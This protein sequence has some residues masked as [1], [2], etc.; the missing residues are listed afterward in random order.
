[1]H[2]NR[3]PLKTE[4]LEKPVE[5]E[6][7]AETKWDILRAS[8]KRQKQQAKEAKRKLIEAV[9]EITPSQTSEREDF[10][11]SAM[12][13]SFARHINE[14]ER[15]WEN[16]IFEMREKPITV[17]LREFN[18]ELNKRTMPYEDK[19]KQ[20]AEFAEA[21]L[22]KISQGTERGKLTKEV[23]I[24]MRDSMINAS[25]VSKLLFKKENEGLKNALR[26]VLGMS[27]KTEK[28][29]ER[30]VSTGKGP[31]FDA[32]RNQLSKDM[33][34]YEHELMPFTWM[35][36]TFMKSVDRVELAKTH[37]SKNALSLEKTIKF[38]EEGNKMGVF[39]PIEME[40]IV[41]T[42]FKKKFKGFS[43][44]K[45]KEYAVKYK[46]QHDFTKQAMKLKPTY[47]AKNKAGEMLTYKNIL[48]FI[49]K[50]AAGLTVAGNV[51][52]GL[53]VG[54]AWKK[55]GKAL[56]NIAT[57]HNIWGAGAVY[58]L[59][60]SA[61]G[62]LRWEDFVKGKS[63]RDMEKKAK[64]QKELYEGISINPGWKEFFEGNNFKG[65]KALADYIGRKSM[66][67]DEKIRP[68]KLKISEFVKWL[69][70]EA[71]KPEKSG[72]KE[73]LENFQKTEKGYEVS[74]FPTK[75][76]NF[77]EF[78]KAFMTLGIGGT[79]VIQNYNNTVERARGQIP[80]T[81]PK[82]T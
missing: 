32:V 47:G 70:K 1:M 44:D 43:P 24:K 38:L 28:G 19:M 26:W 34:N 2:K 48:I 39:S 20:T 64:A 6:K 17:S 37:I 56:E 81:K 54:G 27:K 75:D 46:A 12:M 36:M 62:K 65:A 35:I 23:V 16:T 74:G 33:E 7:Y 15:A 58:G 11:R 4:K 73:L 52:S 5:K 30:A 82:K 21:Y 57:N 60:K 25:L 41:R 55:P 45:I 67:E 68:E 71:K 66:I 69:K 49:A 59:A 72:Y 51:I 3:K 29:G 53:F 78:A 77:K 14:A 80:P 50:L 22:R 40:E 10:I 76:R 9:K 13:E 63:E 42:E 61:E 79:Q 31:A 18:E 8:K